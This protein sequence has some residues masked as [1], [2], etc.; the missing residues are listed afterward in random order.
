VPCARF[1]RS[2]RPR[3]WVPSP[4]DEYHSKPHGHPREKSDGSTRC[5]FPRIFTIC[6]VFVGN[7]RH[8]PIA[9]LQDEM[10]FRFRWPRQHGQLAGTASQHKRNATIT[11]TLKRGGKQQIKTGKRAQSNEKG[12]AHVLLSVVPQMVEP[13]HGKKNNC[14]HHP[15]QSNRVAQG[16]ISRAHAENGLT[17]RPSFVSGTIKPIL[18][19]ANL[20]YSNEQKTR[21]SSQHDNQRTVLG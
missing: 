13:S 17:T 12:S 5:T 2:Q 6:E 14:V 8:T 11:T 9:L 19:H 7:G 16:T 20:G 18:N 1:S 10:D 21:A 3:D 4:K 15:H